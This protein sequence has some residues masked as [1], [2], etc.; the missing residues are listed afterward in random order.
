[1]RLGRG[2]SFGRRVGRWLA[3]GERAAHAASLKRLDIP[4]SSEKS[5]Q[6]CC[7]SEPA[8]AGLP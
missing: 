6:G 2:C 5:W 7:L 3:A 1:M 4:S 8:A